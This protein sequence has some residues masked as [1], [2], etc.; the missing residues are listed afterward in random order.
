MRNIYTD[1][2]GTSAIEP[3]TVVAAILVNP[4]THWFPVLRRI[5]Q[6]WDDQIPKQYR[7]GFVFHAKLLSHGREYPNWYEEA[8]RS[9]MRSIMKLPWEFHIP[10]AVGGVKRGAFDW[11]G[12]PN[13]DKRTMTPAKSDHMMA[14]MCC[15]AQADKFVRENYGHELAQVIAEQNREMGPILR[16]T[17]NLLH[18]KP[19]PIEH[20][21]S[22]RSGS[23]TVVEK[24]DYRVERIIDEVLFLERDNAPFLQIVDACAFG[25]R[26]YLAS[27]THGEDYLHTISGERTI[28]TVPGW[29]MFSGVIHH[30]KVLIEP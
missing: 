27:Q 11:S 3:M 19:F 7:K 30:E 26:R 2:A 8:R 12:W 1:E 28:N 17:V 10:I 15:M 25:I 14:F 18:A 23:T 6:I 29:S 5:R 24:E 4:D 13:K 22:P 16:R 21:S 20:A 9:F